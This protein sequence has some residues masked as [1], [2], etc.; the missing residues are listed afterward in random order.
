MRGEAE[1]GNIRRGDGGRRRR[2]RRRRRW[3]WVGG[4]AGGGLGSV[5]EPAASVVHSVA[6][7]ARL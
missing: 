5:F 6:L 2:R 4:R 7:I 3:W 1:P